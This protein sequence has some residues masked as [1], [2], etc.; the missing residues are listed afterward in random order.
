MKFKILV[1]GAAGYI[2]SMLTTE[3]VRLGYSVIAIDIQKY[4]KNSLL[5]KVNLPVSR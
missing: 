5:F 4:D 3:L 1:T 2:G